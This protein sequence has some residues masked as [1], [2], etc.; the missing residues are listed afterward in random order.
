M[1]TCNGTVTRFGFRSP[2]NRLTE[3]KSNISGMNDEVPGKKSATYLVAPIKHKRKNN[4]KGRC[5]KER[6]RLKEIRHKSHIIQHER[7][8]PGRPQ[9]LVGV[10]GVRDEPLH[11][12]GQRDVGYVESYP[13][14]ED[15]DE[16][17]VQN[18]G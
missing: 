14:E 5:F 7:N 3:R 10:V 1:S 4:T 8:C 6:Q 16:Q 12:G 2:T 18:D 17:D 15:A 11:P 13:K 9:Y